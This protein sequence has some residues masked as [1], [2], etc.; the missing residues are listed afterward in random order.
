MGSLEVTD[1][2][3]AAVATHP[4]VSLHD[5]ESAIASH[6]YIQ[7]AAITGEVGDHILTI[8]LI[9]MKNGFIVIGKA[10]PASPENYNI[11]IGKKFA[12][13]DAIRQLWPLMGFALREKLAN[14]GANNPA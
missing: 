3:S 14:G 4:R 13:E 2:E 11:A 10:A 7:G 5:I 9:K 6:H 12:Y 8:C 1:Q